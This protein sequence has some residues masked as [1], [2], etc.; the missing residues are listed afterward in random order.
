MVSVK[1]L[2]ATSAVA[3]VGF[4]ADFGV[5]AAGAPSNG[6]NDNIDWVAVSD[7]TAVAKETGKPIMTVIHKS[8]CGACKALKPQFA[9][10]EEIEALSSNFVMVNAL[11]DDEP[12]GEGWKPDG[13]YIPRIIFSD[14]S[15]EIHPEIHE[16]PN[17]K[18]LYF[19]SSPAPIVK[20]MNSALSALGSNSEL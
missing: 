12:K 18:Y 15:G 5:D 20:A 19:Y 3:L 13:G 11:D 10:S 17:P 16:G 9:A 8:W 7:A 4:S 6:W 2:L 14:S 1:F